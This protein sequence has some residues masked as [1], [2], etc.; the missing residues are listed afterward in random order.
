[1]IESSF[2]IPNLANGFLLIESQGIGG[3]GVGKVSVVAIN[4]R[5]DYPHARHFKVARIARPLVVDVIINITEE[6]VAVGLGLVR[7]P[8]YF[9]PAP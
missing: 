3:S 4:Q 5:I 8:G 9:V 7:K 6:L 1:M 2:R